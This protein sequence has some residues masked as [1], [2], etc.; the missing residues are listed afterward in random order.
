MRHFAIVAALA[1]LGSLGLAGRA[2]AQV[3]GTRG[4]TMP[5]GGAPTLGY[6]S[7]Y[8]GALY[9]PFRQAPAFAG[10]PAFGGTYG[11]PGFGQP[12]GGGPAFISP[13][14]PNGFTVTRFPT[15][16]PMAPYRGGAFAGGQAF[17][18]W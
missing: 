5:G 2:D 3:Y 9:S 18:R 12:F 7:P 17:R 6:Y 15:Y 11:G 1:M 4:A 13:G 10:G 8:P 16:R 14:Y